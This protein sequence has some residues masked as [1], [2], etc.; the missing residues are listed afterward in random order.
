MIQIKFQHRH[1][2]TILMSLTLSLTYW[3]F[4]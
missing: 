4:I 3:V 1:W 2:A